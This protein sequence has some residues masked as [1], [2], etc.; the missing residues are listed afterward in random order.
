VR[1]VLRILGAIREA[2]G[3]LNLP[4]DIQTLWNFFRKWI[5]PSLS[6]GVIILLGYFRE[7]PFWQV[8]IWAIVAFAL[9]YT[10]VFFLVRSAQRR[11]ST[12]GHSGVPTR[13][14]RT[15][16]AVSI[17]DIDVGETYRPPQQ[18]AY[19]ERRKRIAK[20]RAEIENGNFRRTPLGDS[21]FTATNT[22]QDMKP[23]LL[24]HVRNRFD[25]PIQA[26]RFYDL[27][28]KKPSPSDK[29]VLL[30]EVARIEKEWGVH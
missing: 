6:A 27:A 23:W 17:Q 3:W 24:D 4:F 8:A 18:T 13:S 5:L 1:K 22:Y 7:A 15:A 29:D 14:A 25:S 20:W 28:R 10:L 26:Q 19:D 16:R 30:G 21:P 9:I 11:K 12:S 2:V